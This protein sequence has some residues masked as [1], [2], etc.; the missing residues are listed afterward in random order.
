MGCMS[1]DYSLAHYSFCLAILCVKKKIKSEKSH[2]VM[3]SI[4]VKEVEASRFRQHS[5]LPHLS[6]ACF[7]NWRTWYL[8]GMESL[9][10]LAMCQC[11]RVGHPDAGQTKSSKLAPHLRTWYLSGMESLHGLALRQCSHVGHPDAGSNHVVC[12]GGLGARV[13]PFRDGVP[14]WAGNV[15]GPCWPSRCGSNHAAPGCMAWSARISVQNF[16]FKTSF[17]NGT[18]IVGGLNQ[19]WGLQRTWLWRSSTSSSS[20]RAAWKMAATIITAIGVAATSQKL[21]CMPPRQTRLQPLEPK[22]SI[23]ST[24]SLPPLNVG[25]AMGGPTTSSSSASS[26]IGGQASSEPLASWVPPRGDGQQVQAYARGNKRAAMLIATDVAQREAATE[27]LKDRVFAKSNKSAAA[28]K[29][30]TWVDVARAAGYKDPFALDPD[31]LYTVGGTLWKANYRSIDSYLGVARQEM[32]LLHGNLPEAMAIHFKRISRAAAR[33]RGPAKQASEIPFLSLKELPNTQ[34]PLSLAGPCWPQR[35]AVIS[36]WWLLREIEASNLTLSCVSFNDSEVS[37]RLPASKTDTMGQGTCRGL[38][39]TCSTT[40]ILECPFHVMKAQIDWAASLCSTGPASPV[41]PT[42]TGGPPSKKAVVETIIAMAQSLGLPLHTQSGAPRFTG[43]TFR[44]AGA[45]WLAASGIDVWRIQ[46]HGRWGSSTV[47]QYV[48]LA[49]LASSLA[50]EASL[51]RDLTVVRAAILEAKATLA[52]TEAAAPIP[53][54]D[55]L[56]AA[57][58]PTLG[59]PAKFLGR[60]RADDILGNKSVKGW[61]RF[62]DV[63]ELLVSN[64]GPPQFDGKLHSLKPPR[65]WKGTPPSLA[66]WDFAAGSKAWCSFNYQEAADRCKFKVWDPKNDELLALPICRRCFGKPEA[67][68]LRVLSSSSSGSS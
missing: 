47:L 49:P 56:I 40:T 59:K 23:K 67:R 52:S 54:Q 51:G 34:P 45:M 14:S 3:G 11:S 39:C 18:K 6:F 64:I 9:H 28:I 7:A 25:P 1:D 16:P 41:F 31:L 35:F 36:S 15:P 50:L 20:P 33:G 46:L 10:G 61:S 19:W 42:L 66:D 24:R 30:S 32:I 43:H 55:S 48:R 27:Q 13:V 44:V 37:V 60:P 58:G 53:L 22:A 5:S 2:R 62:P 21:Q 57:L 63:G 12:V 29:L 38:C 4:V 68:T 26:S 8:S 65:K 17:S